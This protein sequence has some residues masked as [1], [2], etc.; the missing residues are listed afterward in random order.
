[1]VQTTKLRG[2]A[3]LYLEDNPGRF[4][5][6][7]QYRKRKGLCPKNDSGA[8]LSWFE[9]SNA[10]DFSMVIFE[11]KTIAPSCLLTFQLK[12]EAHDYVSNKSNVKISGTIYM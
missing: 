2:S 10:F 11:T 5:F 4:F 3:Y 9:D 1:M 7:K 8:F 12:T 6:Q